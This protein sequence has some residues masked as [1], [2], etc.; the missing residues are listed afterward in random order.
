MTGSAADAIVQHGGL[1]GRQ[2]LRHKPFDPETLLG[3]VRGLVA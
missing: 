3:T 1:D 2:P